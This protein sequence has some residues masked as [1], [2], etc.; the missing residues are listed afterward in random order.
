VVSYVCN[1][2]CF[3]GGGRKIWSSKLPSAKLAKL[4]L[5][6]NCKTKGLWVW[7]KWY[8]MCETL[9]SI[10]GT[11]TKQNKTESI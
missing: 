11:A 2:S 6:T 1:P 10:P 4:Y 7:L 9:D 8:S 3:G 5:K